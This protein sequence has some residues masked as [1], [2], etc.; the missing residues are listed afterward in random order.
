MV[1][2]AC[3]PG[4]PQEPDTFPSFTATPTGIPMAVPIGEA[5]GIAASV[6]F[7]G[8]LWVEQDSGNPAE[9]FLI[10]DAGSIVK[11]V[12]VKGASNRDWEDIAYSTG[13]VAGTGYLYLGDIGNNDNTA[14]DTKF[15]RFPE[16]T[17]ATD[18][19]LQYDEIRFQYSDGPRD[20]EA[21]L[22]DPVTHDIV[23]ISKRDNQS[24]VYLLAWPYQAG[25]SS[26]NT[27]TF[28]GE[29][30]YAGVVSASLTLDKTLML[31]K[32][33]GGIYVYEVGAGQSLVQALL[34]NVSR[35]TPYTLEFQGEAVCLSTGAHGFYTLSEAPSGS[36]QTLYFYSSN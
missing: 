15:Y 25:P 17:A 19:V 34:S 10:D 6:N 29:L 3:Q 16:P 28:V 8:K 18:T 27:A 23:I 36:P 13:P 1:F 20:A 21:F 24:R 26:A 7:P 11:K 33:Y 32:I 35:A 4:K 22:V 2:A 12:P 5:S 14:A 31:V 9:I 30:P